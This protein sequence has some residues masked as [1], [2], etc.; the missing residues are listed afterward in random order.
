MI[1]PINTRRYIFVDDNEET[2]YNFL[3]EIHPEYH[4]YFVDRGGDRYFPV[5]GMRVVERKEA[6]EAYLDWTD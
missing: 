2:I 6:Q 4:I 5:K 3:A 1:G